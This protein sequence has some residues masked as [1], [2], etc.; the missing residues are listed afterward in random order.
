MQAPT[1]PAIAHQPLALVNGRL[2]DPAAGKETRGGVLV[3]DGIIRDVGASVIP[4]NLPAHAHA[5]DCAG[6]IVAPG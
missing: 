3:I 2:L 1:T 4:A 6:D 5:I